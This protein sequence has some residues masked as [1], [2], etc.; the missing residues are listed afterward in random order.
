M[1]KLFDINMACIPHVTFIDVLAIANSI[2]CVIVLLNMLMAGTII[3][4]A[5]ALAV[6]S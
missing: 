1:R 5:T 4:K 6:S 2:C 3:A